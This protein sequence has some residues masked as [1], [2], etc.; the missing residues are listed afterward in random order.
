MRVPRN[1][2]F[3]WRFLRPPHVLRPA[4]QCHGVSSIFLYYFFISGYVYCFHHF[5]LYMQD[6]DVPLPPFSLGIS[7]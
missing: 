1:S 4:I 5:D 6:D 2:I 3:L 7:G